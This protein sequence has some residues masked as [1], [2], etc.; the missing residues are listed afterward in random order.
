MSS[1]DHSGTTT[2]ELRLARQIAL[3]FQRRQAVVW[4][5]VD[6]AGPRLAD[7]VTLRDGNG[8]LIAYA[9]PAAR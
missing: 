6:A 3:L 1:A 9:R 4:E 7:D 8:T 5:L 2:A